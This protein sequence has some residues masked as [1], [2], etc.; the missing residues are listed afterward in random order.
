[1]SKALVI[2]NADFRAN[3]LTAVTLDDSIPCTGLSLSIS[4]ISF[5]TLGS[6]QSIIAT[7]TPTNTT[8]NVLWDTSDASV[9]TVSS[10][11]VVTAVGEGAAT[12]T[13]TCGTQTA[14]CSISIVN[15]PEYV[16]VANYNP[17]R[18]GS[19]NHAATVERKT[20]ASTSYHILAANNANTSVLPVE[21]KDGQDTGN[22]RF[23]P[24]V[25]PMGATGM[26]IS[27]E[28]PMKTRML[29]FDNTKV[30]DVNARGAWVVE[31]NISDYFDQDTYSTSITFTKPSDAG[32]NSFAGL[33]YT[34]NHSDAANTDVASI[35]TLTYTYE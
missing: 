15:E 26:V 17:Y 12:I 19:G 9:A 28:Y 34:L 18:R 6:T 22:W 5:T 27:S 14:T 30:S 24:L 16:L 29:W 35:I 23:V 20:A 32:I 11:G 33:I 7:K 1:M 3:K 2:K 31:G 21:D 10:N 8:D 13:A 4:T 25:L